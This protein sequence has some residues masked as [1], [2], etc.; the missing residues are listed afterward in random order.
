MADSFTIRPAREDDVP[1][2][3][4]L[5][6]TMASQHRAYDASV[7]CWSEQAP[8]RWQMH[9]ASAVTDELMVLL[10]AEQDGQLVGFLGGRVADN[11]ELFAVRRA[12]EIW[13]LFVA[14]AAR[15]QGVGK[16]LMVAGE[17]ALRQLGA[18]DVKLHVA[19]K[20]SGAIDFYKR[21]GYQPVMYRMYKRLGSA[22][23]GD[24]KGR[25]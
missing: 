1:A 7:W 23:P 5:W 18:E 10:V 25:A 3:T 24:E 19:L 22:D 11:P 14:D 9:T 20:N 12:G 2:M 15:G 6:E 8:Q 13:D 17:Q 4:R 16:A 21:L